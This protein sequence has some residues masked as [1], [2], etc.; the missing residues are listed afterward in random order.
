MTIIKS[1]CYLENYPFFVIEQSVISALRDA[2]M[3]TAENRRIE[4]TLKTFECY[5]HVT[6]QSLNYLS[7]SSSAFEITI[8]G[9][10]GALYEDDFLTVTDQVRKKYARGLVLALALMKNNIPEM[11]VLE[12]SPSLPEECHSIW[13]SLAHN[14]DMNAIEYWCG[15]ELAYRKKSSAYLKLAPL[16]HSH[17]HEFTRVIYKQ[18]RAHAAKRIRGDNTLINSMAKYLSDNP[19]KWPASTFN[20]PL[21]IVAFFQSFLEHHFLEYHGKQIEINSRLKLWSQFISNIEEAFI[22][23]GIWAK[24]FSEGI[25]KP[26]PKAIYG[27]KARM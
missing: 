2:L 27:A 14:L 5:C 24:P 12:W 26:K 4:T 17:G 8:R 9:Y 11:P 16:W 10:L 1:S 18:W 7:L 20:N 21:K 3:Q 25:P 22:Q 19:D 6:S 23:P 15:W 13:Q